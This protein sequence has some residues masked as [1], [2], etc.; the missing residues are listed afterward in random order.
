MKPPEGDKFPDERE[1]YVPTPGPRITP[2]EVSDFTEDPD[3]VSCKPQP[4]TS[5]YKTQQFW[6]ASL[7]NRS[8]T[9]DT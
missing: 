4:V 2:T 6:F 9:I 7:L 1:E 5:W 3:K 8:V